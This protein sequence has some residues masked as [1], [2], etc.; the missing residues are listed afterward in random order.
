[1][2]GMFLI[3]PVRGKLG[4]TRKERRR[5]YEGKSIEIKMALWVVTIDLGLVAARVVANGHEGRK[6]TGTAAHETTTK[7]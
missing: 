3:Q 2:N 5:G 6:Q 4:G 1:L 7:V